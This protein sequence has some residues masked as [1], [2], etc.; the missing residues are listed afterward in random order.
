MQP[1]PT[2]L[3]QLADIHLPAEPGWWP[4]APGW[5]ILLALAIGALMLFLWWRHR[6]QQ[7]RYRQIALQ[8]LDAIFNQYQQQQNAAD[9]LHQLSVLLRRT[10]ITAYPQ[11]FNASIK[12]TE[13]LNWLDANC[14]ALSTRFSSDL[15]QSLV[16]NAYQKNP[17]VDAHALYQLSK[18]WISLHRTTSARKKIST[19]K[20]ITKKTTTAVETTHV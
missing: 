20:T 15:G 12:G 7:N 18:E 11:S 2:P 16:A 3:D 17:Q 4:L 8:E 13:W 14:P 9:Y 10:A 5:W 1:T 19:K 6:Q